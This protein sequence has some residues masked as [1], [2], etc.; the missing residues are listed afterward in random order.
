MVSIGL[1]PCRAQQRKHHRVIADIVARQATIEQ[2][3][4]L[5]AVSVVN[6]VLSREL[7][8]EGALNGTEW[9]LLCVFSIAN[10]GGEQSSVAH[11]LV[12]VKQLRTDVH[13]SDPLIHANHRSELPIAKRM[14]H[15]VFR[16]YNAFAF[17]AA[18]SNLVAR[19]RS[20]ARMWREMLLGHRNV[21][22]SVQVTV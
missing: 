11:E 5:A 1:N 20:L 15:R 10:G 18:P 4:S 22:A 14:R 17:S 2:S 3:Q 9:N 19:E 13:P 6:P 21:A 8:S 7:D 12:F 16:K